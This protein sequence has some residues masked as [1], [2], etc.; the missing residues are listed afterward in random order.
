MNP[1]QISVTRGTFSN[2]CTSQYD[3]IQNQAIFP[4]IREMIDYVQRRQLSTLLTS[5][6][7]TPYGINA[8]AQTRI[9]NVETKSKPIGADA[10]QFRI[11]GRIEQASV[12]VGQVG[13]SGSDGS[14]SLKMQDNS[15]QKG[16]MPVFYGG[17]KTARVMTGPVASGGG[18]IYTFKT[19]SQEVFDYSTWVAPQSGTKW[20][21]VS[22]TSFGEKSL[23][24]YGYSKFP[25]MF[26]NHM[27]IQRQSISITGDANAQVLWYNYTNAANGKSSKGWMY[28]EVAQLRAKEAVRHERAAWFGASTMKDA[29]GNLLAT[30]NIIDP[31]TGLPVIAG[32]GYEEQVAGGN[33]AYGSGTNGQPILSDFTDMMQTLQ[34]KGNMTT[35]YTWLLVTGTPGYFNWQSVAGEL[36]GA[37]NIQLMQIQNQ[38]SAAGMPKGDGGGPDVG[39]GYN[40]AKINFGGNT[41]ICMQHPIFDDPLAY[42]ELTSDG[43]SV[44]GSTVFIFPLNQGNDYNMEMLHKAA[45]GVDRS[46]V[47]AK[48]NGM[49]GAP[50]A[51]ISQ[52]DAMTYAVLSQKMLNVYNTQ[53]CGIIYPTT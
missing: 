53:L 29:N 25:D 23:K 10:Y 33:T 6:V 38:E 2:E 34:L 4:Q 51:I 37:Q 28:E 40:F 22:H 27:T 24:G 48:L 1:G 49:T 39:V 9:P 50:E 15:L 17:R 45:N 31:D 13:A 30:S 19:P 47:E 44:M 5:G 11:M 35:G 36:V 16:D 42:P 14:F 20:C 52:E 3:L 46:L 12:I 43:K 32:D 21:F 18:Y 26:I 7:V 41:M 8:S